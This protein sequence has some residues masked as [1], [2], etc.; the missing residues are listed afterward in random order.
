MK[1]K[2][3]SKLYQFREDRKLNQAEMAELLAVSPSTYSRLERNETSV[4]FEQVA[5]FSKKL[6]IPIQDFLPDT[7]SVDCHN[8]TQ[9]GVVFGTYNFYANPAA[10]QANMKQEIETLKTQ[11]LH[12]SEL[13]DSLKTQLTDYRNLLSGFKSNT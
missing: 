10:E 1:L 8:N 13:N 11:L 7:V 6:N 3:G 9:G 5:Q 12:L 2:L 4:D